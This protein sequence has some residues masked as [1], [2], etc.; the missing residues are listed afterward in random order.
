MNPKTYRDKAFRARKRGVDRA[1]RGVCGKVTY[2]SRGDARSALKNLAGSGYCQS[3]ELLVTYRCERCNGWH[4]G[5]E[6]RKDIRSG[7][8]RAPGRLESPPSAG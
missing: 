7:L 6:W 3:A 4:V 1:R 5:H 8:K 2:I